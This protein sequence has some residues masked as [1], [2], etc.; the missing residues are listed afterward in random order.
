MPVTIICVEP[1][2]PSQGV[3]LETFWMFKTKLEKPE[4]CSVLKCVERNI[5]YCGVRKQGEKSDYLIPLCSIHGKPGRASEVYDYH[6]A[7]LPKVKPAYMACRYQFSNYFSKEPEMDFVLFANR[8][9]RDAFA[10]MYG[11]QKRDILLPVDERPKRKDP[12]I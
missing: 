10:E 3:N 7:Q 12:G 4:Y 11:L 8:K 6:L 5:S 9:I 1:D 2:Y